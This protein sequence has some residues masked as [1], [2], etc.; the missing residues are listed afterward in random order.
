MSI[1][2]N[3][4][5][6]NKRHLIAIIYL[7]TNDWV[8]RISNRIIHNRHNRNEI[9]SLIILFGK[10]RIIGNNSHETANEIIEIMD[11]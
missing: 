7:N 1:I 6:L 8:N 11:I 4:N 5:Y 3:W 2:V 9:M 10:S